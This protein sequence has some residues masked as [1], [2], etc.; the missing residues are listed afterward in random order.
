ML[1]EGAHCEPVWF[2]N[3]KFNDLEE[4]SDCVVVCRVP[5]ETSPAPDDHSD[6]HARLD[7]LSGGTLRTVVNFVMRGKLPFLLDCEEAVRPL[8]V[9]R[10]MGLPVLA[11]Y[12][13]GFLA[14]NVDR[15]SCLRIM[16]GTVG[17]LQGTDAF[18]KSL[19]HFVFFFDEIRRTAAWSK[20]KGQQRTT[21]T[22]ILLAAF[23]NRPNHIGKLDFFIISLFLLQ[24]FCCFSL[25]LSPQQCN[26]FRYLSALAVSRFFSRLQLAPKCGKRR[27]T[28]AR[29][30]IC[31]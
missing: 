23:V 20:M 28:I 16:A 18:R 2:C 8:R 25:L 29:R 21:C 9:A 13:D 4:G 27:K 14:A 30:L 26:F 10:D 7:A 17:E 22:K 24:W 6:L 19:C 31:A 5:A 11:E 1:R 12:C 15:R 3:D